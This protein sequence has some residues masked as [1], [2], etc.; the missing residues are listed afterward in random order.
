MWLDTLNEKHYKA[1]YEIAIRAEPYHSDMTFEQFS[2]LMSEREGYVIVAPS[3]ELAGCI[4]FSDYVPDVNIIIHC[5]VD[6]KYQK[7]WVTRKLLRTV[8]DYVFGDLGL[9]RI[10]SYCVVGKTDNAGE[11][12]LRL[13]F[14]HEG[15]VRKGIKLGNDYFDIKLFGMLKEECRWL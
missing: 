6:E 7:R 5:V 15:T 10:S 1:V 8:A 4:S 12:L 2:E 14:K 13:G 9:P 11:F 3:G